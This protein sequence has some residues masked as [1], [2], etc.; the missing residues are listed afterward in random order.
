ML[1]NEF[2]YFDED[3]AEMNDKGRYDPSHDSSVVTLSDLRKDR[4]RLTL[5]M[6]NDLRKAGDAREREK[7]E[8]LELVRA[9]YSAP[10]AEPAP[11][12]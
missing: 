7:K 3:Q 11:G 5:K 9:M 4:S 12:L 8:D 6:L 1:L 10:P 2:I